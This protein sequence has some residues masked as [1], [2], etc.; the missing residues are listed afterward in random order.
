M[1]E[2][3]TSTRRGG[4][5]ATTRQ[6]HRHNSRRAFIHHTRQLKSVR[7]RPAVNGVPW[8]VACAP[9]V[10]RPHS[11]AVV[12][13]RARGPHVHAR[14]RR[15][16]A[17]TRPTRPTGSARAAQAFTSAARALGTLV[18]PQTA[19]AP[20]AVLTSAA[21][22]P[23]SMHALAEQLWQR[24][25][26]GGDGARARTRRLHACATTRDEHARVSERQCKHGSQ[27]GRSSD[28][29]H[30][31]ARVL[32]ELHLLARDF[33]CCPRRRH[34]ERHF[35]M[36]ARHFFLH[37]SSDT[38]PASES[39]AGRSREMCGTEK[40]CARTFFEFRRCFHI[41]PRCFEPSRASRR[42][43]G[44]VVSRRL[45]LGLGTSTRA[46]VK[47][48][49]A[50]GRSDARRPASGRT[51]PAAMLRRRAGAGIGR[52]RA[53]EPATI[54]SSEVALGL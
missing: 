36:L 40:V 9:P 8:R 12:E 35:S 4:G 45:F 2:H 22:C 28:Q 1:L 11:R 34:H 44:H 30:F 32:D 54:S 10:T 29:A 13:S 46:P 23:P 14:R 19:A 38:A 27:S 26:G 25:R 39:C 42:H 17:C 20:S 31:V 41:K 7:P 16:R 3:R 48:K 5:G 6:N 37:R 52:G 50:R 49:V 24:Q 51:W 43:D 33:F 53:D 47:D 15:R 21:Q 18:Q